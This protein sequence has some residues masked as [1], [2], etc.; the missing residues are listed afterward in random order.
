MVSLKSNPPFLQLF[1]Q[2]DQSLGG[3]AQAI[4]FPHYERVVVPEVA[5]SILQARP[6]GFGAGNGGL[7]DAFA[8]G[9]LQGVDLK[10]EILV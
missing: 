2:V 10:I 7:E 3:A 1:H 8:A 5:E 9:F 4:Q 6:I